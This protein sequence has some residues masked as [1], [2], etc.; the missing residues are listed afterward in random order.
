MAE[1][2]QDNKP[3]TGIDTPISGT[4]PFDFSSNPGDSVESALSFNLDDEGDLQVERLE[5]LGESTKSAQST[6]S[7]ESVDQ[8]KNETASPEDIEED[9]TYIKDPFLGDLS[10]REQ[11]LLEKNKELEERLN[12]LEGRVVSKDTAEKKAQKEKQVRAKLEESGFTDAQIEAILEINPMEVGSSQ[13]EDS[14]DKKDIDKIDEDKLNREVGEVFQYYN[15]QDDRPTVQEMKPYVDFTTMRFGQNLSEIPLLS[16]FRLAENAPFIQWMDNQYRGQIITADG[17]KK[18]LYDN[19]TPR[20][21]FDASESLRRLY[22]QQRGKPISSYDHLR[23]VE[24]DESKNG[25]PSNEAVSRLSQEHIRE[26][27]RNVPGG[28]IETEEDRKE[29]ERPKDARTVAMETINS[30]MGD[31]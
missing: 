11:E 19:L 4:E 13:D 23:L 18:V 14:Q 7:T 21:I 12:N 1:P 15:G 10:P 6:E 30:F 28:E 17:G 31:N 26:V 27:S 8:S 2:T 29:R 22:Y 20:Q 3:T 16:S 5:T 24:K 25:K 9:P